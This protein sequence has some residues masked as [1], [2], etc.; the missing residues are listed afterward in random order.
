MGDHGRLWCDGM[1]RATQL[2]F[3]NLLIISNY[4]RDGSVNRRTTLDQKPVDK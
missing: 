4:E 2:F 1:M 3:W